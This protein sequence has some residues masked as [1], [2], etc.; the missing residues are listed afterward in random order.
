M[1]DVLVLNSSYEAL[2]TV[3][4]QR[5]VRLLFTGK[6][7]TVEAQSRSLKSP[8]VEIPIPSIIR[9]LYYIRRPRQR[10]ALSKKNVLLRDDHTCQYCGTVGDGRDLTID[11][12]IPR[13]AGGDSTWENLATACSTCN[14]R[15]GARTPEQ[16]RM[17]LRRRPKRPAFIPWLVVRRRTA[18]DE[19]AKY[20]LWDISVEERVDTR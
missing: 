11:H 4:L 15:K 7:E 2:S 12:V 1:S 5:A 8:S 19:W 16:A 17:T 14:Q 10:V 20:L 6:A 13:R 18:P 9:M 3:T